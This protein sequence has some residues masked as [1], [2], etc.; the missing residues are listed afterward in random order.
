MLSRL[1]SSEYSPADPKLSGEITFAE[2]LSISFYQTVDNTEDEE[3]KSYHY[4]YQSITMEL[5]RGLAGPYFPPQVE[6]NHQERVLG[7]HDHPPYIQKLFRILN[8]NSST[9]QKSR[10][11][12]CN[13]G[14]KR[15][16]I[17]RF[18]RINGKTGDWIAE[19][20]RNQPTIGLPYVSSGLRLSDGQF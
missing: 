9:E 6:S 5:P 2:C 7:Y 3:H 10:G 4:Q 15:N 16:W 18:C 13:Q 12:N 14:E 20:H 8:N 11:Q 1:R 19:K 17:M